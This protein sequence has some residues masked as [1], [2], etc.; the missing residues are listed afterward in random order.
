MI[1]DPSLVSGGDCFSHWHSSDR[2]PTQDMLHGLRGVVR[3]TLISST[4]T[5]RP[6]DDVILVSGA[7]TVTLPLA[8]NSQEYTIVRTG[9]ST[10]TVNTTSPDTVSGG[11]SVTLTTQWASRT[12]KAIQGGWVI[13]NGYL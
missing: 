2:V 9:T 3:T 6:D 4:Y 10:V 5:A 8:R 13:I 7:T 11:S 1:E 12:F